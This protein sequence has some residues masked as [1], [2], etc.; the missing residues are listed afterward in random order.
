MNGWDVLD[1]LKS[2]PTLASIPVIMVTVVD[3]EAL[4]LERGASNYLV[5]PIDRDRLAEA[6]DKHRRPDEDAMALALSGDR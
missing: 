6:L 4:G 3:H 2:D 5:K 1:Q